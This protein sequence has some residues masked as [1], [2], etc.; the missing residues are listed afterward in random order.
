MD[1]ADACKSWLRPL[2]LKTPPDIYVIALEEMVDLNMINIV[3]SGSASDEKAAHWTLMMKN[4][5]NAKNDE[6]HEGYSLIIEKHMVGLYCA[7]FVRDGLIRY[8]NDIR[9][10]FV[11]TGAMVGLGNKGKTNMPVTALTVF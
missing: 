3:V 10:A 8:T 1:E 4:I 7:V 11:P 5:L 2:S 9:Y 6:G